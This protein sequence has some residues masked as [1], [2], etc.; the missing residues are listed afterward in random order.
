[1]G[2]FSFGNGS[3]GF[4]AALL[5]LFLFV[6]AERC[7]GGPGTVSRGNPQAVYYTFKGGKGGGVAVANVDRSSG[8][9]LSQEVL[10]ESPSFLRPHK[11]KVS[12]SGRYLLATSPHAAR[13]NLLLVDLAHQTHQFL[14]VDRM[15]DDLAAWEDCFVVGAEEQMCY[16][17]DAESGKVAQRWNGKH[18]L[19][20]DGRR[21]EYV[22][23]TSDGTAWTSWQKDSGSGTRKGSRVVTINIASGETIADLQ[24]PR[25]MP[26]LHLADAKERGPNPEI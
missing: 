20:S 1:M 25:A 4:G 15:P 13:H 23:T 3:A 9:I 24:M 19:R 14:S 2:I 26:Q 17:V 7:V 22:A 6:P 11:L 10:A 5:T 12:E 18:E 21:I 16:I 8:R